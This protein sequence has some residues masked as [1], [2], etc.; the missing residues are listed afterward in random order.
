M[1]GPRSLLAIGWVLPL[2]T[3]SKSDP[4]TYDNTRASCLVIL[5]PTSNSYTSGAKLSLSV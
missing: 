1:Q 2:F 4:K 3:G 5:V